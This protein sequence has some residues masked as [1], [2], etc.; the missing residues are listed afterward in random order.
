MK[1]KDNELLIIQTSDSSGIFVTKELFPYDDPDMEQLCYSISEGYNPL[2]WLDNWHTDL[3]KVINLIEFPKQNISCKRDY[4]SWWLNCRPS[5]VDDSVKSILKKRLEVYHLTGEIQNTFRN[6]KYG[7]EFNS[8]CLLEWHTILNVEYDKKLLELI[9]KDENNRYNEINTVTVYFEGFMYL[10]YSRIS[11][12]RDAFSTFQNFLDYLYGLI[13][14]EV[15]Q[16]SYGEQ[17]ILFNTMSGLILQKD[18]INVMQP[19][20]ELKINHND[21]LICYKK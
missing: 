17:W 10:P 19:L 14:N 9:P 11:L 18:N 2:Y 7:L 21:K 8:D 20:T 4:I 3:Q 1:T 15:N 13:R 5:F 6:I 12:K 16:F